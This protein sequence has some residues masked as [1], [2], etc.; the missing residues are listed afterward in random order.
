MPA[1]SLASK[2]IWQGTINSFPPPGWQQEGDLPLK[3]AAPRTYL[4]ACSGPQCTLIFPPSGAPAAPFPTAG[5]AP[6]NATGS[7]SSAQV[8]NP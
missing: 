2:S 4:A 3:D 1:S 7:P 6:C 5:P 8:P